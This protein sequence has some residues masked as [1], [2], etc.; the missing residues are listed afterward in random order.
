MKV[1]L[2]VYAEHGDSLSF[3]A[4]APEYRALGMK[5]I[6]AAEKKARNTGKAEAFFLTLET[7]TY[8]RAFKQNAAT[9]VLVEAI[10]ENMEGRKPTEPEK[11]SLY[12]D[13]L[14]E[15]AMSVPSK[16]NPKRLRPVHLSVA[17]TKEAAFFIDGLLGH[18]AEQA[19]LTVGL[20]ATVQDVMREWH[21]W[22][23]QMEEDPVDGLTVKEWRERRR[24]SDASGAGGSIE[25]CHIVSRGADA[26]AVDKPWNWLAL[27]RGEHSYQHQYGWNKFLELF[28][29]L[30]GRVNRARRLAQKG[31]NHVGV[32]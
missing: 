12:C 19:G 29:H 3:R 27:T 28:P 23:G 4:A 26:A 31:E 5:F 17:D 32:Y 24:Y 30:R 13:L 16:I 20:Q 8:R 1:K 9:W 22:R 14:A 15:Y 10:F 7:Q 6:E 18:L 2:L 11:Y 25:L 21:N